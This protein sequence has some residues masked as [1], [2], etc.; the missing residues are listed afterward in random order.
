MCLTSPRASTRK[1]HPKWG[2]RKSHEKATK[3]TRKHLNFAWPMC[4]QRVQ[5]AGLEP[6]AT[7]LTM[8]GFRLPPCRFNC[9]VVVVA[10]PWNNCTNTQRLGVAE[11][12][13]QS[14][15]DILREKI[16]RKNAFLSAEIWTWKREKK[17]CQTIFPG[18]W[19]CS[20]CRVSF[21]K[22]H[23]RQPVFFSAWHQ[24]E[25]LLSWL[26]SQHVTP[27]CQQNVLDQKKAKP[28]KEFWCCLLGRAPFTKTTVNKFKK[29]WWRG[30]APGVGNTNTVFPPFFFPHPF[31]FFC[32]VRPTLPQPIFLP[33]IPSFSDLGSTLSGRE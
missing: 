3:R 30:S 25:S 20:V 2:P 18:F 14:V 29:I 11:E 31:S 26:C 28:S 33:K 12:I 17:K 9:S 24:S 10:I 27:A 16:A 7:S 23:N 13:R 5:W 32:P 1:I 21:S 22:S 19:W 15:R 8:Q 6:E 4:Q